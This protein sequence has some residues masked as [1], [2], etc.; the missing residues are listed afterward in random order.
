MRRESIS[1]FIYTNMSGY[2]GIERDDIITSISKEIMATG[3]KE[4][5]AYHT[6]SAIY[7]GCDY[8]ISTDSRLLKYRTDKIKLV[9]PVEFV[10]EME[11]E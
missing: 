5:D 9:N 2:I 10:A 4:K 7:A 11:G 8:F 3:V 1:S 6:A